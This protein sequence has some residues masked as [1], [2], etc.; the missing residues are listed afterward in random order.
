MFTDMVGYTVLG[1]RNESLSLAM[2]KEQR[3]LVRPILGRYNG[4]EVK[5]MGDAFLVE[6]PSALEAVRCAYEIQ[7]AAREFSIPLPEERRVHLRIGLH[8]GDVV[9]SDGDISGDAVNIASRIEPLAEDGG[10]CLTREVFNQVSNKIELRMESI[11]ARPLKNVASPVEVY[12][13]EFPWEGR[14]PTKE[15]HPDPK[16]IAVLPFASLSPN[17][18]DEYFADGMTEELISTL[19]N[20]QG[21]TILSRTSIMQY[22]GAKKSAADIGRELEAGTILEGSVRKAGSRVRITVQL[23]DPSEDKHLFAQSYDRDLSD[24]FVVQSEI[25]ELVA[26]SLKVKMLSDVK[27]RIGRGYTEDT[28]SYTSYLQGL[29]RMRTYHHEDMPEAIRLFESAISRDPGFAAAYAALSE[30]YTYGAGEIFSEESGFQKGIEYAEKAVELDERLADGHASLGILAI[31]NL[32][33]WNLAEHELKRAIELN[34][35]HAIAHMW[36]GDFLMLGGMFE[37]A[38]LESKRAEEL[39]PLSGFVR[40]HAGKILLA[41]RRYGESISKLKESLSIRDAQ[42]RAHVLIGFCYILNGMVGEGLAEM[43]RANELSMGL[44]MTLGPL[45]YALGKAGL[46]AEAI[47]AVKKLSAGD[48]YGIIS[49]FDIALAYTGLGDVDKAVEALGKAHQRREALVVLFNPD[50]FPMFD[51]IRS[52]PRFRAILDSLGL[53]A[54][55][56]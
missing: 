31:Q 12:R 37:E 16:R 11:G 28:E 41:A 43:R 51:P 2:L 15:T 20:V 4:R 14:R 39:D 53:K 19:S 29:Y 47:A 32:W 26:D 24:I 38:I 1:Q 36:Y 8:L 7:R 30:V 48:R 45:G 10:V 54:K 44:A 22:K 5:T 46:P 13:I 40:W 50:V 17:P 33:D 25:A 21:F 35:S 27:G 56:L 55:V 42:L 18:N 23:I 34:P 6:F 3:K 52:D 9:E 49:F